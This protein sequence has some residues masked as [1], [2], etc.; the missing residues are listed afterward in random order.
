VEETWEGVA[1]VA[2]LIQDRRRNPVGA[3][4]VSGAVE[5]V[6]QDGFPRPSLVA[7]VRSA[8]RAISRDLG[9]GRF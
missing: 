6:C 5:T 3:V 4:C 7:S 9:A 8:A 2:A 1:S